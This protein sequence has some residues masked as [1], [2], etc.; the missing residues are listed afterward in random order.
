L[1]NNDFIV[2]KFTAKN[3]EGK[4]VFEDGNKHV[5]FRRKYDFA[6]LETPKEAI[7]FYLI[8]DGNFQKHV[9]LLPRE[10]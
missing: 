9:L 7:K 8:F 5:L 6:D 3:N 10:Y 2:V 1:G 4:L